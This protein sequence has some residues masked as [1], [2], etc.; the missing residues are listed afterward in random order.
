MSP[1]PRNSE[2]FKGGPGPQIADP[3]PQIADPGPQ[4]ANPGPQITDP[5]PQIADPTKA[6]NL[7][8]FGFTISV[9][10]VISF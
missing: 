10:R 1:G 3:G 5:G 8:S 7:K 2:G 9:P 4:I 6:G